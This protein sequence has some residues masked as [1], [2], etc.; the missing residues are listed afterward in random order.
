MKLSTV[1]LVGPA[2][3]PLGGGL[4]RAG[5]AAEDGAETGDQLAD[6]EG[7]GDVVVGAGV[8]AAD[9]V[10]LLGAGGQHDDGHQA[11]EAAQLLADLEPVG[12][13]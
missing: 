2:S 1:R 5:G 4:G 11:I 10:D 9:L 8:E 7:L 3:T 13:G 12:V 6:A